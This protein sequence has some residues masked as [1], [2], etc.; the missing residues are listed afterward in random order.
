MGELNCSLPAHE[1]R[2]WGLAQRCSLP[3]IC[4]KAPDEN[5][6]RGD[7][8]MIDESDE[9]GR[10]MLERFARGVSRHRFL[11][12]AAKGVAVTFAALAAGQLGIR[13]VSAH[14]VGCC[15]GQPYNTSHTRD[16]NE[17]GYQCPTSCGGG[18]TTGS[19]PGGSFFVCQ[20][21]TCSAYCDYPNGYWDCYCPGDGKYHHC[22]DCVPYDPTSGVVAC[23]SA[24][25]CSR[26]PC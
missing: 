24:C 9:R 17:V 10:R 18:G 21:P 25:T 1:C 22:T 20:Q 4:V 3:A 14:Q 13:V 12:T 16:C 2:A 6:R 19:C 11:E 7:V 23:D 26:A 8:D 15:C 5:R